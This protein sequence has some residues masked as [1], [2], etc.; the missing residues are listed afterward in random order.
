MMDSEFSQLNI[1][2][3]KEK[4]QLRRIIQFWF[5]GISFDTNGNGVWWQTQDSQCL[6][7][8]SSNVSTFYF[9]KFISLDDFYKK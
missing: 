5:G 7:E 8:N 3:S 2:F 9:V 6:M 1:I 4:S